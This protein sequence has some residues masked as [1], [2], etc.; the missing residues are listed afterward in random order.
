M[1]SSMKKSSFIEATKKKWFYPVMYGAAA[2]AIAG[3]VWGYD[4]MTTEETSLPVTSME[5]NDVGP[6]PVTIQPTATEEV[7]TY[8]YDEAMLDEIFVVQPFYEVD[9]TEEERSKSI[10]VF[11]QTYSTSAGVTLSK[12]EEPFEVRAALSG[13][14][15]N[16]I[17]DEFM[18]NAVVLSHENGLETFYR[19]VTEIS[20]KVGD[21][22]KQGQALATTSTNHWNQTAGNHLLFEVKENGKT[23]NPAKFV[24]F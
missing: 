20:V 19:S 3:L 12:G 7:M 17:E 16:I 4:V 14:V 10:M 5:I 9:A 22:V 24:A 1:N 15:T 21:S 23:V 18:G 13:K 11:G 2:I 8:P 6:G